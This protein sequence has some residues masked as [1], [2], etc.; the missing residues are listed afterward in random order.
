LAGILAADVVGYSAMIGADEPGT[1]ARVRALRADVVEPLAAAHEGRVFKTTGDGFLAAFASAVQALRCAIAIQ[2][3]LRSRGDGLRLRIGVH[4]GEVV[5]EGN[6]LLGDGVI[7]A[8]RLEPLAEPGGICISARVCEDAAGKLALE[9]DDLGTPELK[10]ITQPVR[11]FRVRLD[12]PERPA[13]PL[14]ERP[15]LA[16]LPFQNMSGDPEQEY[17]ADGVVEDITTALSR[18]GW[19]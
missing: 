16:V 1:L 12:A 7:V 19:L 2:D 14:P 3:A 11:V 5:P 17:F 6:D 13:L 15:S 4:Q 10:N 9:V 18:T 8:A